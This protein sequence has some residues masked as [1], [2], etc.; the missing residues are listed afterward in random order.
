[1]VWKSIPN[2]GIRDWVK[3]QAYA[4]IRKV[5]KQNS[6]KNFGKN[7]KNS[8]QKLLYLEEGL[9]GKWRK[10]VMKIMRG[11]L[12]VFKVKRKR[13]LYVC[14]VKY[15]RHTASVSKTNTSDLWHKRLGHVSVK[16]RP[17][18]TMVTN[19][20][21]SLSK[22]FEMKDLD[23]KLTS[24]P[25]AAH[26]Q[27]CK[28]QCPKTV[29]EKEQMKNTSYSNAIGSIM[30]LMEALNWLLRYLNG[31]DNYGITFS[32]N[33]Q[34]A[35]LVGYVDS[36]Y[37]ND[38]DNKNLLHS[39]CLLC[40]EHVLAGNHNFRILLPSQRLPPLFLSQSLVLWFLPV[41]AFL[42]VFSLRP[43]MAT[44]YKM[45]R[46]VSGFPVVASLCGY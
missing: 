13:N 1:M 17:S 8:L 44:H 27:L 45:V 43:L 22:T 35:S 39:M 9:E 28:D 16:A 40:V 23:S 38:R 18:I 10:G 2:S 30:Y 4:R 21:N 29:S 41:T 15:E 42:L 34:G 14:S 20:Q 3:A 5:G 26:F 46:L 33:P 6:A 7:L 19:L 11:S 32:K 25:L 12:T 24:V 37:A 36:N 31:S